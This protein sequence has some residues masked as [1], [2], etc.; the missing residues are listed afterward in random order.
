DEACVLF[1]ASA[2]SVSAHENPAGTPMP[3]PTTTLDDDSGSAV[4]RTELRVTI[5]LPVVPTK[6]LCELAFSVATVPL[7]VSVTVA[8]AMGGVGGS[9]LVFSPQPAPRRA[10]TIDTGNTTLIQP[11]LVFLPRCRAATRC[12]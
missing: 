11:C 2:P 10:R 3:R 12:G 1:D 6:K 4:G 8:S 9:R 5:S 7:N